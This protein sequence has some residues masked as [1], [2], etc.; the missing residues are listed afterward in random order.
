MATAEYRRGLDYAIEAGR[1]ADK[2]GDRRRL[3]HALS[4]QCV[5][6]R[7]MGMTDEAI[8]PGRLALEIATETRDTELAATTNF[9]LG[10]AYMNRGE[11]AEAIACCRAATSA[12]EGA[13]TPERLAGLH[14]FES[15]ARSWLAW[16]LSRQGEFTEALAIGKLA[17]E[18]AQARGSK[19]AESSHACLLANVW[20]G[21]GDVAKAIGILEPALGI[22]RAYDVRDWFAPVAMNLGYAYAL[23]G[24]VADGI[25]LLEEGRTHAE[26]IKQ[27]TNYPARLANLAEAYALAGRSDEAAA[28]AKRA[29]S[30]ASEHRLRADE[31]QCLEVLGR[32]AAGADPPDVSA[33]E[34]YFTQSR[35]LAASLGMRPLVAHCHLDLARL[36][37]S[38]G[39]PDDA[40]AHFTRASA[41]YR[42]MDM[43]IW[44]E[45]A[46]ADARYFAGV[47]SDDP[48]PSSGRPTK[49]RRPSPS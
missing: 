28:T 24:R 29:S 39:R 15:G 27:T 7:V 4:N 1:L 41:M 17:L 10:T 20:L 23:V 49:T 16:A 26:A 25:C 8:A 46:E 36:Y 35:E 2:A 31:A 22:S 47:Y 37:R 5:M 3:G 18:I 48:E 40:V 9:F 32:L 33:A 42:E 11:F 6:F 44:L 30:L 38:A 34:K 14:H 45:K 21:L 12:F 43:R 19:L 13:V